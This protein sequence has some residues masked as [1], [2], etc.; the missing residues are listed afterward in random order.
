MRHRIRPFLHSRPMR[1]TQLGIGWVLLVLA[2]LIG[3][4]LPGPLGI[5]GFAAGLALVLRNSH[6]ARRRYVRLKQRYPK[7]GH[8]GDVGLRRRRRR[9]ED[10]SGI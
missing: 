4:P 6:W 3:G 5:L 8:W 1:L 9:R 7:L 2:P 10:A